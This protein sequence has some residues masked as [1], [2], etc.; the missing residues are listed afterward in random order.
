MSAEA[1][2]MTDL[3]VARAAIAR[4]PESVSLREISEQLAIMAAIRKGESEIEADHFVTHEEAKRS[5][6]PLKEIAGR[7]GSDSSAMLTAVSEHG[8]RR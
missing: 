3:Q 8:T 6:D 4:M 5:A 1:P 2:T 7:I